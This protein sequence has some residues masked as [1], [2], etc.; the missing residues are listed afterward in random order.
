MEQRFLLKSSMAKFK[1]KLN[2]N[3]NYSMIL[4]MN[5]LNQIVLYKFLRTQL[6]KHKSLA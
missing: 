1:Y 6:K 4:T 3:I 5:N 2:I